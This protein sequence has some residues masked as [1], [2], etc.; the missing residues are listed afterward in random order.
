MQGLAS[1]RGLWGVVCYVVPFIE[2]LVCEVFDDNLVYLFHEHSDF[3]F[4][5]FESF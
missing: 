5:H 3:I 4:G 1:K 2:Y